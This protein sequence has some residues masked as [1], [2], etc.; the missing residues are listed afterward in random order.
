MTKS[1][2]LHL[3]NKKQNPFKIWVQAV[4]V[5]SFTATIIP[6]FIGAA[7][8]LSY[9]GIVRWELFPLIFLA[10]L[11]LH[12]GTNV[13]SDYYDF[14]KGV[15]KDYTFGSSRVLVDNLL[16]PKQ[17]FIGA[18]I[19]FATACLIGT[20]FIAIRGLPILIIGLIGLLGGF[21]YTGKPVGYK[22][23]ALGDLFV[24]IL[25]GPLMVVGS[26]L[27]LTGAFSTK[28]LTT[29]FPIACMVVA[30]LHANNL[31]DIDHDKKAGVK[32]CA[33]LLGHEKAKTEYFILILIAYI[34]IIFMV[35]TN[36][37]SWISL[38]VLLSLPI[39]IKNIKTVRKSVA[40]NPK[41]I[42]T[43]DAQTAQLH[44]AFGALFFISLIL[45]KLFL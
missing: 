20:M 27:T 9:E 31:R 41:K 1:I 37:V 36:I 32:T 12:A 25:M 43:I 45:E 15:D 30:I 8:A 10:S 26:Y 39:A 44:L 7:L 16:K 38:C 2:D 5:F 22:Y 29:S 40:G 6:I 18:I 33:N 24:F 34:S 21:L 35:F 17:L 14:K 28:A 23:V 13:I 3:K 4:R 19:F 11:L 42:S